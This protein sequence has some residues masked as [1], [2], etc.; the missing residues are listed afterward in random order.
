MKYII[1]MK[2]SVR[3]KEAKVEDYP[4]RRIKTLL[5]PSTVGSS[6]FILGVITYLPGCTVEPHTHDD[7]EG[8]YVMKGRGKAKIGGES[9]ELEQGVAFYI[10]KRV[11]HSV[12]NPFDEPLE[13]VFSHAPVCNS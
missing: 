4:G 11:T 7:Q 6:G 2:I 1:A 3:L 12:M 9:I 13:V 8:I 10:A 5:D